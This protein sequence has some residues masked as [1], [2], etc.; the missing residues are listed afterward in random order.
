MT[1]GK[2]LWLYHLQQSLDN[3]IT[4]VEICVSEQAI[5]SFYSSLIVFSVSLTDHKIGV[6]RT[7]Y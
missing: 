1:A 3:L 6:T 7:K 4:A 5:L 2:Q